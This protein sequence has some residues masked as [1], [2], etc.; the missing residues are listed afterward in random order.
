MGPSFLG[1]KFACISTDT[2][3]WS[4]RF[5]KTSVKQSSWKEIFKVYSFK[6]TYYVFSFLFTLPF[7]SSYL[8]IYLF[9]YCSQSS[10][11]RHF[12][13]DGIFS[14][15][16]CSSL[17]DICTYSPRRTVLLYYLKIF[18]FLSLTNQIVVQ[19]GVPNFLFQA[20]LFSLYEDHFGMQPHYSSIR[21]NR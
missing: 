3:L 16:G 21:F 15:Y 19:K 4:P 20:I 8:F 7:R 11:K 12:L 6:N 10:I 5:L 1:R 2:N 9:I 18:K 17:H 14:A 13:F